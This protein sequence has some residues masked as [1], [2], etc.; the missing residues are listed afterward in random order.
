MVLAARPWAADIL[1]CWFR[2]LRPQD[3]FRQ[4]DPVD[5][6]LQI[7]FERHLSALAH[8]SASEFLTAPHM[9]LAAVLL[10]DQIPRNIRRDH[11]SSFATDP[12]ARAITRGALGR[13]W[14]RTLDRDERQFLAMPLMHSETIADQIGSL[15]YFSR[16]NPATLPFAR[17]HWRMIT[18]FGRF[19]HRNDVLG[20]HTTDKEQRAIDVGFAW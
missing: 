7:R 15:A 18:R 8:C 20:R 13:G 3:W 1:H 9:A 16:W 12:L 17:S 2:E 14:H 11:A 19:P 6:M 4:S 5:T 10:F